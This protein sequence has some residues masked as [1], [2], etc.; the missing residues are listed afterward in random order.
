MEFIQNKSRLNSSILLVTVLCFFLLWSCGGEGSSEDSAS[1]TGVLSFNVVYHGADSDYQSKAA[2]IDCAGQGVTTVEAKVYG[3]DNAFLAGGGPWNCDTGQG[4]ISSVPAGSGRTVVVFGKDA[5]GNVVFSGQKSGIQ[6]DADSEIDAG[7]IECFAFVP[8][9]QAPAD[10]SVTKAGAMEL[11]WNDVAGANQYRVIVSEN[12]DMSDPII[13]TTA[14]L[15]YTTSDLSDAKTYFWQVYAI[16]IFGNSGIGSMIWSFTA[17]AN[18]LPIATII[19]PEED[20]SYTADS[21]LVFAGSGSDSEDGDLNGEYLV[22]SSDVDG[23]IG[24]GETCSSDTLIAGVHQIT[25]TAT[26]SEGATGIDTVEINIPAGRLPDTGQITSYTDTFG[27]DADYSINPSVYTKIDASGNTLD[28]DDAV[29]A[30]V[31]DDVTGLIW[32][33]KT[34]SGS[35][36]DKDNRYAWQV[37]QDTF[38]AQ[39]NS[40]N[41]GGHSDWRL[42]THKELTVLVHRGKNIPA[43]NTHYFPNTISEAYWTSTTLDNVENAYSVYFN[44]GDTHGYNKSQNWY[45]R[46]VRGGQNFSN[47]ADNDDGTVTDTVTG[48]MWQQTEAGEMTWEKAIDYCETLKLG[49]YDDWRL[50]NINELQSIVSDNKYNPSIDT[51]LFPEADSSIYWSST[52]VVAGYTH[53]WFVDFYA[54]SIGYYSNDKSYSYYVRA[55]RGGQ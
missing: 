13:D 17:S 21:T 40:D 15:N 44:A 26:D 29:W 20:T 19:I 47:F 52:T 38:I 14:T 39:L 25:L 45:V 11:E 27:E 28:D 5:D 53:A 18:N 34:D 33:V 23:L 42:P 6:V 9:L 50:P 10:G 31:R 3:Q 8:S 46:A 37:A 35:I 49:G 48:L 41:Y 4:T 32:E 24:T 30:M 7:T 22:W 2:L 43:I 36:H 1:G 55:V 54:G 16:D 51:I 12:S